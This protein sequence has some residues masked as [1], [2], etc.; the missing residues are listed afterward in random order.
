MRNTPVLALPS[1][2]ERFT[3]ETDAS[4]KAIGA[5]LMQH[6]RPIAFLSQALGS[7]NQGLSIYERVAVINYSSD[8]VEA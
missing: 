1:F 8:K 4:C 6:G 2:S 7:K 5:V 3:V